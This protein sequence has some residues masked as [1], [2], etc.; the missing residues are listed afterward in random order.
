MNS[1]NKT[2]VKFLSVISYI[3]PLFVVGKFSFEKNSDQL[4]FHNKQGEILF[5]LMSTL[6]LISVFL[7][8]TFSF[9]LDCLSIIGLLFNISIAVTWIILA[10]MGIVSAFSSSKLCLPI[11]GS[12]A[13]NKLNKEG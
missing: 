6:S 13:A 3:G 10:V 2:N 8:Y 7:D 5:Y 9:M 1:Y 4:K 12:F 11:I